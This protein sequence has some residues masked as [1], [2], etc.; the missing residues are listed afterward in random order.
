LKE[1]VVASCNSIAEKYNYKNIQFIAGD[2]SKMQAYQGH[3]DAII[4][5]HACDSATDYALFFAM[6]NKV[7]H[8]FSVPCCQHEINAQI[9]NDG[10]FS[11]L[12]KHSLYK[13]RLSAILTDCVRCEI[14]ENSGY[15]VDVVEFVDIGNT[16]KNAMIRARLS[17]SAKA[18]DPSGARISVGTQ[19]LLDDLHVTHKLIRLLK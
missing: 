3:A 1:D 8:I 19:K 11:T 9:A 7:E 16:P 6:Q 5:L 4:T 17:D 18:P 2:I 14:L 12:L 15:T 13:E 10:E